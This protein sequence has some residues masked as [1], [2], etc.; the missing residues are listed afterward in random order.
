ME[1]RNS[2]VASVHVRVCFKILPKSDLGIFPVITQCGAR[3]EY[4]G[5]LSKKPMTRKEIYSARHIE[6]TGRRHGQE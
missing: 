3:L 4:G 5:D 6:E 1:E 2:S